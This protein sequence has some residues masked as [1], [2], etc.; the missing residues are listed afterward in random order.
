MLVHTHEDQ[1]QQDPQQHVML[2]SCTVLCTPTPEAAQAPTLM[3]ACSHVCLA[4]FMTGS[5]SSQLLIQEDLSLM[6]QTVKQA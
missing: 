4:T 3:F 5:P 2:V 6:W 1:H